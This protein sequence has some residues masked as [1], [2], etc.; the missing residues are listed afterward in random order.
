MPSFSAVASY[1]ATYTLAK[2]IVSFGLY[3][4]ST[5]QVVSNI[6]VRPAI[7]KDST[8]DSYALSNSSLTPIVEY[9]TKMG[10]KNLLNL[11]Y[12]YEQEIN[13]VTFKVNAIEGTITVNGTASANTFF[14]IQLNE[15]VTKSLYSKWVGKILTGAPAGAS[16]STYRLS[17]PIYNSSNTYIAEKYDYGSG[18][19]LSPVNNADMAK[20][21]I[22]VYKDAT[23]SN[24][25]FKPML[26]EAFIKDSTFEPYAMSNSE[27]TK[28]EKKAPER[29]NWQAFDESSIRD[30]GDSIISGYADDVAGKSGYCV[31]R[32]YYTWDRRI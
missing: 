18:V 5:G 23:V 2:P 3:N 26:R 6:M 30:V 20:I 27:L 8:F 28:L 19:E 25:V 9:N 29:E 22:T 16:T 12:S 10:V 11:T 4:S 14:D 21:T 13:D 31:I 7:I 1:S 24:L 15:N 32:T 17:V